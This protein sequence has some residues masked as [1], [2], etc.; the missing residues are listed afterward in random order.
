MSIRL[1]PTSSSLNTLEFF[2]TVE[3]FVT[4]AGGVQGVDDCSLCLAGCTKDI[5]VFAYLADQEDEYK[6]DFSSFILDLPKGAT[7]EATLIQLLPDGTEVSHVLNS[8]TYGQYFPTGTIRTKVWG[9]IV[10]WNK[11]AD[12]LAFGWYKINIVVKN[13]ALNVL[14]DTTTPC[15]RLKPYSCEAAHGTVRIT[16]E[17]RGYIENGFD[18]EDIDYTLILPS[19]KGV[20]KTSWPQQLRWYGKFLAVVPTLQTD[21]LIDGNRNTRQ[22]QAQIFDNFTLRLEHVQ[23]IVSTPFL[24]DQLLSNA[25]YVADYNINNPEKYTEKQ[26]NPVDIASRTTTS[27]NKNEFFVIN[28]EETNK[29]TLKRN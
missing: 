12:V 5:P 23:P 27:L 28:M 29:A 8:N 1:T 19:G 10:E 3:S 25:I 17:S 22:I 13:V 21:N 7:V 4:I 6:N 9:F 14:S 16:T 26:V 18:Y 24:R 15:Y 2:S 11:V 20:T